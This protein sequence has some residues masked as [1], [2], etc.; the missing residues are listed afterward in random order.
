MNIKSYIQNEKL[1]NDSGSIVLAAV[2]TFTMGAHRSIHSFA[3]L[4][5]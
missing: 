3:S 2:Y 4:L 1:V 5:P